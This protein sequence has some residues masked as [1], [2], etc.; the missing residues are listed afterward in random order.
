MNSY[1]YCVYN[2]A[3]ECFLSL[4]TARYRY[5]RT[6]LTRLLRKHSRGAHDSVWVPSLSQWGLRDMLW[7][8]DILYLD[9]ARRVLDLV[10]S[11]P[12]RR[13]ASVDRG[14]AS[15]LLLAEDTIRASHTERGDQLLVCS[16]E[17]MER[18]LA[19]IF[20]DPNAVKDPRAPAIEHL[21]GRLA[22]GSASRHSDGTGAPL[23]VAR[24]WS[25]NGVTV[26]PIKHISGT[27]L[28]L[29][30]TQR[31]PIGATVTLSVHPLVPV[32]AHRQR[33]VSTKARVVSWG[34]DGV[35][36]EFIT[37]EPRLTIPDFLCE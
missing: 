36:L 24:R 26:D 14:A 27:G 28:Y 12:L 29:V 16:V 5:C 7:S 15:V 18:Q 21:M 22:G 30:T 33:Q 6:L 25:E 10:R 31:W 13:V 23:F 2:Y 4:D 9:E 3:S 19:H 11:T 32:S 34:A 8:G 37:G 35:D 17:E 20:A 1:R